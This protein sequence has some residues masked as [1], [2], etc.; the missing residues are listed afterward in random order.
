MAKGQGG[1]GCVGGVKGPRLGTLGNDILTGYRIDRPAGDDTITG[2]AGTDILVAGLGH[3][4]ILGLV[5]SDFISGGAG[6]DYMD[7]G[8]GGGVDRLAGTGVRV[9]F[10]SAVFV[11]RHTL[12]FHLPSKA[13]L[14]IY[15]VV[16]ETAKFQHSGHGWNGWNGSV[17]SRP[18][19]AT[20]S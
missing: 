4:R 6:N 15:D 16:D 2:T 5:G 13:G 9:V 17:W 18:G 19:Q 7:G 12:P 3:D 20:P 14:A 10:D 1:V 8:L 11:S